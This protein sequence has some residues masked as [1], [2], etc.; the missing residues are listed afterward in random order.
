MVL[1]NLTY[2]FRQNAPLGQSG[3]LNAL[4]SARA[5]IEVRNAYPTEADFETAFDLCLYAS[6]PEMW[7]EA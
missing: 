2:P 5:M 7:E 1:T 4:G 6:G 3:M